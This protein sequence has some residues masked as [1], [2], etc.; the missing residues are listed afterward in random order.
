M[1][2]FARRHASAALKT[3][4]KFLHLGTLFTSGALSG[5]PQAGMHLT[6][7]IADVSRAEKSMA[8]QTRPFATRSGGKSDQFYYGPQPTK[9]RYDDDFGLFPIDFEYDPTPVRNVLVVKKWQ[10][11]TAIRYAKVIIEWLLK[12]GYN[13]FVEPTHLADFPGHSLPSVFDIMNYVDPDFAAIFARTFPDA[14]EAGCFPIDQSP[15][16]RYFADPNAI[17]APQIEGHASWIRA[18]LPDPSV[19]QGF[20][21]P[22]EV[23]DILSQLDPREAIAL[24]RKFS[25][26]QNAIDLCV[27]VG[28]DGT[29]LHVSSLFP[30]RVPP[31]LAFSAGS[32]GFLMPFNPQRVET[33]LAQLFDGK[34]LLFNRTRL[35]FKLGGVKG[36]D[37]RGAPY[38]PEFS[39]DDSECYHLLNEVVLKH[40][41]G[42]N[43]GQGIA[44]IECRIDG[45]LL[46]RF[47][48]DGVMVAT[49]TGS[50]AY[51][52][53][54]GGSIVHPAMRSLVLS[55]ICPMTLS[56][57]PL[58]LPGQC[59][60][61]F[62]PIHDSV[63]LE[64]KYGRVVQP[65][66]IVTV[67]RSKFP[68]PVFSRKGATQDWVSDMGTRMNYSRLV[69]VRRIDDP[70]SE[71]P[72]FA[73]PASLMSGFTGADT[74][75]QPQPTALSPQCSAFAAPSPSPTPSPSPSPIPPSSPAPP[76]SPVATPA[77][78]A[79]KGQQ[80][81]A[82][83]EDEDPNVIPG[84]FVQK[85]RDG[86]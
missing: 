84:D 11:K 66:E 67:R 24:C 45:E 8:R 54:A 32:F 13:V 22:P 51:S 43:V 74:G 83:W 29:L 17:P 39:C 28:G 76:P 78:P 40:T 15:A 12:R 6:V 16:V 33:T 23:T 26:W 30:H 41:Y 21:R 82:E 9:A 10:N 70:D 81:P 42:M 56:S 68:I 85:L 69:R 73:A 55:P 47:Q 44:E 71:V 7:A 49:P 27:C 86:Q 31:T 65:D 20:T 36:V 79:T 57:R 75:S 3:S 19:W 25:T 34:L 37:A 5:V 38:V 63:L 58:V 64:G 52:M 53:A 14:Y 46:A 59:T 62:R 4:P 48:G 77:I 60:V 2:R 18:P 50:T 61:T 35:A 1:R 72:K 80:E